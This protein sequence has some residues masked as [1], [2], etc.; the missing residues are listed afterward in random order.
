MGIGEREIFLSSEFC[1]FMGAKTGQ[2]AQWVPGGVESTDSPTVKQWKPGEVRGLGSAR[3][4]IIHSFRTAES[5]NRP[6][7][8]GLT[9]GWA[10][11]VHREEKNQPP[12]GDSPTLLLADSSL[13]PHCRLVL[14]FSK[15]LF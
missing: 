11:K 10:E 14:I 12:D 7:G 3:K 2:R 5:P 1:S 8:I 15:R 4:V 6:T 13:L 9:P